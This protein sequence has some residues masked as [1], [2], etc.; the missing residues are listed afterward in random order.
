MGRTGKSWLNNPDR[1]RVGAVG[2]W[3][4]R[5]GC[6]LRRHTRMTAAADPAATAATTSPVPAVSQGR[7]W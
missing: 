7:P 4:T 6:P 3:G 1:K 5:P 2:N